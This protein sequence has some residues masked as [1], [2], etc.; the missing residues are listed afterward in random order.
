LGTFNCIACSNEA[1]TA[2][3]AEGKCGVSILS[4]AATDR[5]AGDGRKGCYNTAQ[6]GRDVTTQ[7]RTEGM[8]QHSTEYEGTGYK[9]R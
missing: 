1:H 7:H 8:L 4:V 9:A 5:I 3:D 6:N 2:G